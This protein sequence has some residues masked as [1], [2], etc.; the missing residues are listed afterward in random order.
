VEVGN[1]KKFF[2]PRLDPLFFFMPLALGTM[3]VPATIIT[4]VEPM[5][6]RVVATVDMTTQGSSAAFSQGVQGSCLP[7]VVTIFG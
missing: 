2:F 7:A 1:I 5:A 6:G 3:A 4:K